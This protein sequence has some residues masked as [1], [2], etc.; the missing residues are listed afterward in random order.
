MW[1]RRSNMLATSTNIM[2]SKVK[3]KWTKIK[4]DTFEEIKRIV[5]HNTLLEYPDFNE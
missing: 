1:A 2:S 3:F 5:A 4:Q